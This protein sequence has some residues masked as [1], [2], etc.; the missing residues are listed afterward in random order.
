[1]NRNRRHKI[2]RILAKL[3]AKK[4]VTKR[5]IP[6]TEIVYSDKEI[7]AARR[8]LDTI[9]NNASKVAP[10]PQVRFSAKVKK[11]VQEP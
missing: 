8:V 1:M 11:Y 4:S 2:D 3:R 9:L 10:V 5:V 7:K 6:C